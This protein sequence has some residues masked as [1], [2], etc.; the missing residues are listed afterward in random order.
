MASG[1]FFYIF[2]IRETPPKPK[3]EDENRNGFKRNGNGIC[4]EEKIKE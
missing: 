2:G 3:D 1:F 4:H